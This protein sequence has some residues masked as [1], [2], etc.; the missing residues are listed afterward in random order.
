VAPSDARTVYAGALVR[1][2][3]DSRI[4]VT[5][6]ADVPNPAWTNISAGLPPRTVT[7][8]AID[9][10][11]SQTAY[12]TF[13]GFSGFRGDTQG[14]VFKTTNA[15]GSW[16]D[17][18][19]S[20]PNALPNIPVNDIVIDPDTPGTL[21]LAT[22]TGVYFT[23]DT[24]STWA[25]LG[26]GLP[27]TQVMGLKLFRPTR[28]L[29]AVTYGRSAWDLPVGTA[30]PTVSLSPTSLAFADQTVG[31]TSDPQNVTLTN[32]GSATLNISSITLG[33]TN[34]GDFA[35]DA[36]TMC[37]LTAGQVAAGTSCIIAVTFTP[38]AAGARSASV[39]IADDAPGSPQSVPLN[40]NGIAAAPAV[41]LV[42][43]SLG[44]GTQTVGS[45]SDPQSVTLTNTGT[46]PLNITSI[47]LGGGIPGDYAF[48]PSTTCP[49]TGGQVAPGDSCMIA[50]TFTPSDVGTRTA[51]VSISDN[52]PGSPQTI[53][54]TG[55][56]AA[57]M[58]ASKFRGPLNFS[59]VKANL[60]IYRGG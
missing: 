20:S 56:G 57:A 5:T 22:D 1:D 26:T 28:T 35:F 41:T 31:S 42:P 17:I 27:L 3:T 2:P 52:A 40:G 37:P 24:G 21:Y 51:Q 48:D 45:T 58:S 14:H 54:L 50:L 32:T 34:P 4:Q 49:L 13:S 59:K 43:A 19:G 46:A 11:N 30:G 10:A 16:T 53:P 55:V 39:S 12:A 18:S 29:R 9:P 36:T 60:P 25:P 6:N 8:I 15:G 38:T 33:G 44:F 47:A 7:Q 23:T